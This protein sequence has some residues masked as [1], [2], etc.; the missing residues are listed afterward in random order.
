MMDVVLN[1]LV[2]HA[3]DMDVRV[4]RLKQ[5]ERW[6]GFTRPYFD[7]D[8]LYCNLS[9]AMRYSYERSLHRYHANV[10]HTCITIYGRKHIMQNF[11]CTYSSLHAV[12]QSLRVGKVIITF[13]PKYSSGGACTKNLAL[14]FQE[15]SMDEFLQKLDSTFYFQL[16]AKTKNPFKYLTQYLA[17]ACFAIIYELSR[18]YAKPLANKG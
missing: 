8:M 1:I 18:S 5:K 11:C 15:N 3:V 17:F 14:A 16:D 7:T 6:H 4:C 13:T 2:M 9:N 10:L 12:A